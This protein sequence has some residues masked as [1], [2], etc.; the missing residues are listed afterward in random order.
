MIK[1]SSLK[2]LSL[3]SEFDFEGY[4]SLILNI[5]KEVTH[6]HFYTSSILVIILFHDI[7]RPHVFWLIQQK[8][9]D[10]VYVTQSAGA[11]E[12]TDCFFAEG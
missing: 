9:T 7:P 8:L 2:V 3:L 5:K 11:V 4:M 1:M 10:I 12:Y 6:L